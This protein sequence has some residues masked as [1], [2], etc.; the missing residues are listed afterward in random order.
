MTFSTG[1]LVFAT[2]SLLL[3]TFLSWSTYQSGKILQENPPDTNLLLSTPE[4][5]ARFV[6]VGLCIG[7]GLASDLDLTRL[8]W[9]LADPWVSL[10]KGAVLGVAVQIPLSWLTRAVV[11][12][13][14]AGKDIYSPVVVRLILPKTRR[15]AALVALAFVPAVF[16][17]EMLF[18]SLLVGGFSVLFNPWV[19]GLVWAMV[20]GSMHLPQGSLGMIATSFIGFILAGAF[21]VS[22][23]LLVPIAAHYV[24][25]ILQVWDADRHKEWLKAFP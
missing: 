8:G 21:I 15:E 11:N 10:L 7:L 4:N 12:R 16:M 13:L 24:I 22:G 9:T 18:R 3:V 2:G 23:G 17:E 25:N 6:L 5:V 20:F 19:L 14:G 1:Y